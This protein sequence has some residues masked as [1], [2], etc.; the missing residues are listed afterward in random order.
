MFFAGIITS[1]L[2]YIL[3]AGVFGTFL[4]SQV[5]G[6]DQQEAEEQASEESFHRQIYS[7]PTGSSD[8]HGDTYV[9]AQHKEASGGKEETRPPGADNRLFPRPPAP[10][11]WYTRLF[12]Y[13]V[14]P[15]GLH[16]PNATYTL[17]GPP[18]IA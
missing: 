5:S 6:N 9:V 10:D 14:H 17:R 15:C 4:V 1:A 13:P 16:N 3:L 11:N 12:F 18:V 2:P 8:L 7:N